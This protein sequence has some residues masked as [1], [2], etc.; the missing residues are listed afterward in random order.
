[1]KI[2]VIPDVHL[3]P[4]L[5]DV[6]DEILS[7]RRADASVCL[8][9]LA[10]DWDMAFHIDAY[11]ETYDRAIAFAKKY[12]ASMW[13]YG[14]HDVSYIWGRTETGYSPY[15][16]N[17]VI[18]KLGEL[19]RLVLGRDNTK[20]GFV[21]RQDNVLFAH[22]GLT[23]RFAQ[24]IHP[25]L[26]QSDV[27]EFLELL[28]SQRAETLWRDDSPL[29]YRPQYGNEVMYAADRYLQVVGHTPV[30]TIHMKDGVVSTDVFSTRSN[31]TQIGE[32]AMLL[33]DTVTREM[34]KIPVEH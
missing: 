16:E 32:S 9:D 31:G 5:F 2:I 33:I 23:Q 14:N 27:D 6:A 19:Q 22:G 34:Q 20:M 13:C 11:E 4:W 24:W 21:L 12:P 15:A 18:R 8:M 17:T 1:M 7:D 3:K 29:W 28:N 10:D 30:E 26:S 25:I